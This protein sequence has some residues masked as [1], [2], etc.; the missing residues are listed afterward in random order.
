M[1]RTHQLVGE[2]ITRVE[3]SDSV[4]ALT[5]DDGP[6]HAYT[7]YVPVPN[8]PAPPHDMPWRPRSVVGQVAYLK[9]QS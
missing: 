4:V 3:T 5:F 7:D 2:L 9:N 8:R 6:V 1:S